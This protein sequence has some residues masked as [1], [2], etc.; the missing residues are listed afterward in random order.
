M[1]LAHHGS[2]LWS[3]HA[4]EVEHGYIRLAVVVDSKVQCGQLVVGGEIRSLTGVRQKGGLVHI[5]PGQQQLRVC[6]VLEEINGLR[7]ILVCKRQLIKEEMPWET[8]YVLNK[9]TSGGSEI[10]KAILS[11]TVTMRVWFGKDL[12]IWYSSSFMGHG[13]IISQHTVILCILLYIAIFHIVHWKCK[14]RAE[15]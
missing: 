15:I 8:W 5:G 10:H 3:V 2:V 14:N 12:M 9:Q 4:G 11:H 1:A 7:W 6:I 13:M